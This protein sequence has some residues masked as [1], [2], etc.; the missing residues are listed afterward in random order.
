MGKKNGADLSSEQLKRLL[1]SERMIRL[2]SL[3]WMK[4]KLK[5]SSKQMDILMVELTRQKKSDH[6]LMKG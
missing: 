2:C 5:V 1:W 3:G 6:T 4:V